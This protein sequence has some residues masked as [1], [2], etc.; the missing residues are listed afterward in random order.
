MPTHQPYPG[1]GLIT[2]AVCVL[3]PASKYAH[4]RRYEGY[5]KGVTKHPIKRLDRLRLSRVT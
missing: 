2:Y 3:N 4:T 1:R 5:A